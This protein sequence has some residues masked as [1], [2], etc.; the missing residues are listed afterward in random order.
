MVHP[1]LNKSNIVGSLLLRCFAQ[2][3][4]GCFFGLSI[5]AIDSIERNKGKIA[6]AGNSGVEAGEGVVFWT[7]NGKGVEDEI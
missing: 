2:S 7:E 1:T 5:T 6:K 4:S 3:V